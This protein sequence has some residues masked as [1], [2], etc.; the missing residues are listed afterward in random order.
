MSRGAFLPLICIFSFLF[1]QEFCGGPDHFGV[2]AAC[3]SKH[4]FLCVVIVGDFAD[5][6]LE[7]RPDLVLSTPRRESRESDEGS[8]VWRWLINL[9]GHLTVWRKER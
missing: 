5:V 8:A 1:I 6:K 4:S 9:R 3:E 7:A 2:K